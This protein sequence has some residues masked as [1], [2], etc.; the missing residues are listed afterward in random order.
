M[1]KG[2]AKNK[3]CY[4]ST[5]QQISPETP[6]YF[7]LTEKLWNCEVPNINGGHT[8]RIQWHTEV[9]WSLR[10][11]SLMWATIYAPQRQ[12][13]LQ[14]NNACCP[15]SQLTFIKALPSV[16]HSIRHFR[17][18]Q[19]TLTLKCPWKYAM[20]QIVILPLGFCCLRAWASPPVVILCFLWAYHGG[21]GTVVS[22]IL[23]W[24]PAC[25]VLERE[26]WQFNNWVCL[27]LSSI[28]LEAVPFD[29]PSWVFS[30]SHFSLYLFDLKLK[31]V[32]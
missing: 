2:T 4:W 18:N 3:H 11:F 23:T 14:V 5:L 12:E 22:R 13:L 20:G 25:Y 24:K 26:I 7:T 27:L 15:L 10:H 9:T 19:A 29:V 8:F 17:A 32:N 1:R 28:R 21:V 31:S 6:V 16:C 30:S